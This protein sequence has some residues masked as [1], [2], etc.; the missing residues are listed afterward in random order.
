[1]RRA[2]SGR[3]IVLTSNHGHLLDDDTV[4]QGREAGERWR[5]D[6]GAAS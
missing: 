2:A 3:A 5:E 1:M 6:T 4:F